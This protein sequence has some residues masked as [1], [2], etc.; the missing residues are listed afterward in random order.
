MDPS[1]HRVGFCH[2]L[3]EWSLWTSPSHLISSHAGVLIFKKWESW[4]QFH[5]AAS[6]KTRQLLA[7]GLAYGTAR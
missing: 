1:I 4:Y 7:Q 5:M 3:T 6:E 2:L